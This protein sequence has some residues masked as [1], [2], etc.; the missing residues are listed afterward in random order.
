MPSK[1]VTMLD[2]FATT[3]TFTEVVADSLDE[4]RFRILA[5]IETYRKLLS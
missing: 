3:A 1:S 5:K 2:P 4:A